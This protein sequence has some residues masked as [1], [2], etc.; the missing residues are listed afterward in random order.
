MK[1]TPKYVFFFHKNDVCSN[2]Y[3]CHLSYNGLPF[4]SSEQLFMYLKATYFNDRQIAN[5]ILKAS[6]PNEAKRLGR[7]VRRYDD[8]KWSQVRSKMMLKALTVKYHDCQ[9]F[10]D[11]LTTYSTKTFVEASPYDTIWGIGIGMNDKRLM[12]PSSWPGQNLLGKCINAVI[13][14]FI[15]STPKEK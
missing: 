12:D 15:I 6:T 8:E 9:D 13:D 5:A 3:P 7:A 14:S 11:I 2:F 4:H 1:V 10:K